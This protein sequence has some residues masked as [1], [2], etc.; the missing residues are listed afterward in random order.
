MKRF[1]TLITFLVLTTFYGF[2]QGE[3]FTV[4]SV[5]GSV[6]VKP[7]NET[8]W[9][10]VKSLDKVCSTDLV[11][12]TQGSAWKLKDSQGRLSTVPNV[13]G[14]T[15]VGNYVEKARKN[16]N[17]SFF[18]DFV[19]G[20]KSTMGKAVKRVLNRDM[21][22]RRSVSVTNRYDSLYTAIYYFWKSGKENSTPNLLLNKAA[23]KDSI[24]LEI[25]N[26]GDLEG[27]GNVVRVTKD[28]TMTVMYDFVQPYG[29]IPIPPTTTVSLK[30]F[31]FVEQEDGCIYILFFSTEPYPI[32]AEHLLPLLEKV[33]KPSAASAEKV[34]F[35]RCR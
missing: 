35:V 30:D 19:S 25:V 16:A 29:V 23:S 8:E 32:D 26:E 18:G 11:L 28:G 24:W 4:H 12:F 33:H 34:D 14:Q 31:P 7:S 13:S 20:T 22:S 15:S 21:V 9:K 27:Y 6:K 17:K 1:F 5:S 10:Q 2:S 3:F